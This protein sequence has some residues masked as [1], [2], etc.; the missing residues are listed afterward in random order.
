M[1]DY[2]IKI[3][4]PGVDVL[5]ATPEDC[6][7]H[8]SYDTFKIDDHADPAHFGVVK[9]TFTKDSA[10]ATLF[11]FKHGYDHRPSCMA[12]NYDGSRPNNPYAIGGKFFIQGDT[13]INTVV[14]DTYFRVKLVKGS[15]QPPNMTGKSYTIRYYIFA[16]DGD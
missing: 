4:L 16:E 11:S 9:I 5:K 12:H 7:V 6:A 2:G 10:S 3:S 8:S 13:Y 14:D 1:S 15:F